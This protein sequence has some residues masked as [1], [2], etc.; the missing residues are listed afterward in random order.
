MPGHELATAAENM[1]AAAPKY[2]LPH[3]PDAFATLLMAAGLATPIASPALGIAAGID[4][5]A[6]ESNEAA[7]DGHSQG[8]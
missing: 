8:L 7:G 5:S 4:S 3:Y 6:A 2:Q 1:D